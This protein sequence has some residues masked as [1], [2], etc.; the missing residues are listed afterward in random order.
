MS[1]RETFWRVS[2]WDLQN[3]NREPEFDQVQK[4]NI[5]AEAEDIRSHEA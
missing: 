5:V 4:V 3:Q 1:T 2:G